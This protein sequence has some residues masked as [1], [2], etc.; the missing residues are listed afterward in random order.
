MIEKKPN[1]LEFKKRI[2]K[3]KNRLDKLKNHGF[4][5]SKT[6]NNDL[7]SLEKK[8]IKSSLIYRIWDKKISIIIGIVF[9]ISIFVIF[10]IIYTPPEENSSEILS[11]E[12]MKLDIVN[13]YDGLIINESYPIEG[14]ANHSNGDILLVQ[15][16]LDDRN[17]ENASGTYDWNYF[18]IIDDLIEGRHILYFRCWDGEGHS[19][20]INKMII[21]REDVIINTIV[22]IHNPQDG[23]TDLS[24]IVY[25]NGTANAGTNEIDI[26]EIQFDKGSWENVTGVSSWH[27]N[28]NTSGVG[29]HYIRVRCIDVLGYSNFTEIYVSVFNNESDKDFELPEFEGGYF[30]I[31]FITKESQLMKPGKTYSVDVYHRRKE[32]TGNE[33]RN[34]IKTTLEIRAIPDW[35]NVE[36]PKD[37]II[38]PPDN[39]TYIDK[40]DISISND[41]PQDA[42]RSFTIYFVTYRAKVLDLI[43]KVVSIFPF[44]EDLFDSLFK[45]D[46]QDVYI[47]TGQ[48]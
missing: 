10:N 31:Y 23:D 12:S 6:I 4:I 22:V 45:A 43:N 16:K 1:T 46:S 30:Q 48:W 5:F 37:T 38:T 19:D 28:W 44:F 26:V 11:D 29:G 24:G 33:Y 15:V 47:Y 42:T 13:V 40:I 14:T 17:W 35:L 2:S 18:L 9:I 3:C 39:V 8:L 41:A 32:A 25:I 36:I 27:K 34:T 7:D 20:V 21:I